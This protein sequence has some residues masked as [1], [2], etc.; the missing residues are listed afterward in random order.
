M[1][2]GA[3]SQGGTMQGNGEFAVVDLMV[4]GTEHGSHEP[5]REMRLAPSRLR[6]RHPLDRKTERFLKCQTMG[7]TRLIVDGQRNDECAFA[8]QVDGHSGRLLEFSREV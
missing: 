4:L 2:L 1:D 7:H 3:C 5:R 8:S 6:G